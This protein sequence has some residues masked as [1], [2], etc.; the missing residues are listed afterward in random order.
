MHQKKKL[1]TTGANFVW[2]YYYLCWGPVIESQYNN[3]ATS[4]IWGLTLWS[5]HL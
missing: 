1:L 3:R 5:L 2:I 4:N